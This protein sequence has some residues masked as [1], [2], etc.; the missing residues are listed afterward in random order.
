MSA[1]MSVG[2]LRELLER[3]NAAVAAWEATGCAEEDAAFEASVVA[4]EALDAAVAEV[5]GPLLDLYD[6]YGATPFLGTDC[7][8][9]EAFVRCLEVLETSTVVEV[10]DAPELSREELS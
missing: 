8:A 6:A 5:L 10:A 9:D 1:G 3:R 4:V 2:R 7:E